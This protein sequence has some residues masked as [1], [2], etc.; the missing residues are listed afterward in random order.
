MKRCVRILLALTKLQVK[1]KL[2]G[3]ACAVWLDKS[4]SDLAVFN[5]QGVA[6]ASSAAKDRSSII[7]VKLKCLCELGS[8][9][10]NKSNLQTISGSSFW[11]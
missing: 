5:L 1:R 7:K 2:T 9:I 11:W 6:L 8:W 3:G 10:G 4:S